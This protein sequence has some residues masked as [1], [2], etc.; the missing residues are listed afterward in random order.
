VE[1]DAHPPSFFYKFCVPAGEFGGTI[2]DESF[3][4]ANVVREINKGFSCI[5]P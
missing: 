2:G 5:F 4:Y 3:W 1:H